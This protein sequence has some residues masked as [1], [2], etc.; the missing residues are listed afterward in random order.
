MRLHGTKRKSAIL[1]LGYV[2]WG[3]STK[4]V[5]AEGATKP[6]LYCK[7]GME[8]QTVEDF[9]RAQGYGL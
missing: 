7:A 2:E 9:Q 6:T 1:S 8:G 3:R 5:M 4:I